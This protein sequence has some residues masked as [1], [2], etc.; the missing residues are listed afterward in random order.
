MSRSST[1]GE[2][3]STAFAFS[4]EVNAGRR[5]AG[6]RKPPI[7][8]IQPDREVG[9]EAPMSPV[10]SSVRLPNRPPEFCDHDACLSERISLVLLVTQ[11]GCA[12]A[13]GR[14]IHFA[15]TGCVRTCYERLGRR[16]GSG[17]C[18]GCGRAKAIP[19]SSFRHS[20][21]TIGSWHTQRLKN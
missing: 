19:N 13:K 10:S 17:G 9:S 2:E 1:T 15:K 6:T 8:L 3:R 4:A 20:W 12:R 7:G 16:R 18:R 5:V 11:Q 21:K 14:Q